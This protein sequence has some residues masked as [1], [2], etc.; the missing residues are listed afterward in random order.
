MP[1]AMPVKHALREGLRNSRE[2]T[3]FDAFNRLEGPGEAA[4]TS[5]CSCAVTASGAGL[6]SR[7]QSSREGIVAPGCSKL[8]RSASQRATR[9]GGW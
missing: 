6:R 8:S 1:H 2:R 3:R 5:P 4:G 9:R 7:Y